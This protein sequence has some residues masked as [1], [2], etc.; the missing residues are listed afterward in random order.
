MS[1][2]DRKGMDP[3][4]CA[5]CA[6]VSTTC[7]TI[8]PGA[9]EHCF[10]LSALERDRIL[11]WMGDRRGGFEQEPNSE[12]FLANMRGL[13]PCEPELLERAFPSTK[14]HFRLAA[15]DGK[16]AFL[17][18]EGCGL[19]RQV[20]PYYCRLFPLW[21]RG[22]RVTMFDAPD[23]LA[24]REGRNIYRVLKSLAMTETQVRDLYG[25]L[26][27]AWGLTPREGMCPDEDV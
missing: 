11:D 26:R 14:H 13:F 9:E 22:K 24:V 8:P 15:P 2:C 21:M 6:A 18:E 3:H 20:R 27:M 5:R 4:I 19:P 10:P 17:T 23:C 7:C 1:V 25:R 12:V 16:C